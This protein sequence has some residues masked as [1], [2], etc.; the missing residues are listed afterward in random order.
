MGSIILFL[1]LGSDFIPRLNEGDMVIGL[2][3]DTRIGIDH[4]VEMQARS[5]NVISRF[6]EVKHVFS[7]MGTPE[8]ATD[9]MGVNFADTFVILEKDTLPWPLVN[10]RVRT[11]DELFRDIAAAIDNEVPG[12]EISQ[13]QPIEMRF[14]EIL[15]G[16]RA[17]ITMRDF[18]TQSRSSL[19]SGAKRGDPG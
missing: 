7:R 1:F 10:G 18:R 15:E 6:K 2:V 9:P 3:R 19:R 17:D 16:S 4:S 12:Q 8:S 13:T 5:D 11:M 14:N